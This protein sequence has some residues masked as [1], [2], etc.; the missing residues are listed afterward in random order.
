MDVLQVALLV[1]TLLCSLVAGFVFAFAVGPMEPPRRSHTRGQPLAERCGVRHA[2]PDGGAA[3]DGV[4]EA[5]AVG[6]DG[7]RHAAALDR[8]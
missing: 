2:R 8:A 1:A 3:E 7:A 4:A 6:A 5:A